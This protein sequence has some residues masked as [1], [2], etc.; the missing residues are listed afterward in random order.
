M[1]YLTRGRKL[2]VLKQND[3]GDFENYRVPGSNEACNFVELM[4]TYATDERRV[5][6]KGEMSKYT[7]DDDRKNKKTKKPACTVQNSKEE[8]Y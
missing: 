2:N 3:N 5:E 1:K 6:G 4:S 8:K 7:D